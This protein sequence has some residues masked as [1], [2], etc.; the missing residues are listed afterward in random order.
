M[1]MPGAKNGLFRGRVGIGGMDESTIVY[2]RALAG[3]LAAIVAGVHLLHPTL[4]GRALFVYAQVG[5]L[6]DPRPLVFTLGAFAL[7]FGLVAGVNGLTGRTM[8]VGGL[9]VAFC[10]FVGYPIWHT[11]LDHGAFWPYLEYPGHAHGNPVVVVLRHL[12]DN[13]LALVSTVAE[14]MLL[15]VLIVLLR[16][17]S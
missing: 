11:V 2:L 15:A 17:D 13:P 1:R 12:F 4:G 6:G 9:V 10:F 7:V 3:I 14:L 16:V 5:Y 8:Y